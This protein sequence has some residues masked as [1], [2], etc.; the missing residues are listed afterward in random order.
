MLALI[1]MLVG[2]GLV[3]LV[4]TYFQRRNKPDESEIVV[5]IDEECCGA[6][7]ICERDTLLSSEILIVYF[8]DEELDTLADIQAVDF[9]ED[10]V[11]QLSEVFYTLKE[12]DVAGWLRS[13]QMRRIQL[14]LELREEA[15][16]IVS[17]RRMTN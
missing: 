11:K 12:S 5:Q 16:M 9:T 3:L 6:H 10:Q 1:L 7:A 4:F 13:L 17:E 2:L 14:P 8:D 15:L